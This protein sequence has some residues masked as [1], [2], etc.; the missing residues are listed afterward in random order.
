MKR[1]V[2]V[3]GLG[4][5]LSSCASGA[6]FLANIEDAPNWF[7]EQIP[8]AEAQGYPTMAETP[9]VPKDV[10]PLSSWDEKLLNLK[11]KGDAVMA[12]EQTKQMEAPVN[13]ETFLA[14]SLRRADV[15]KYNAQQEEDEAR[16]KAELTGEQK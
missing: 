14:Q 4:L 10:P 2:F 8:E 3:L 16:A 1:V 13:T 6:K 7:V 9:Q 12:A 11:A 5:L 15:E